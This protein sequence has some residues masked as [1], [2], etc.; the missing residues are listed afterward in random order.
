MA[1]VTLNDYKEATGEQYTAEQE[2]RIVRLLDSAE[3]M[4]TRAVGVAFYD[5]LLPEG[6]E[7]EDWREAVIL[8]VQRMEYMDHP[9][10]RR[11]LASPFE[12]EKIGDWTYKLKQGAADPLAIERVVQIVQQYRTTADQGTDRLGVTLAGPSRLREELGIDDELSGDL[13]Y[14]VSRRVYEVW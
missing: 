7:S 6:E 10:V 2:R 8:I 13:R 12:S 9:T 14:D 4:L 11:L 1:F 3:R 5:E